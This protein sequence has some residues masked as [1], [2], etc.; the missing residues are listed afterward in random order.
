MRYE[1]RGK[2]PGQH[3]QQGSVVKGRWSRVWAWLGLAEATHGA[4]AVASASFGTVVGVAVCLLPVIAIFDPMPLL[5]ACAVGGILASGSG[6]WVWRS[7]R[8]GLATFLGTSGLLGAGF[9]SHVGTGSVG[10]PTSILYLA[11][12]ITAGGLQ[13]RRAAVVASTVAVALI[14]VGVSFGGALRAGLP[15]FEADYVVDERILLIFVLASIPCWG[16]YVVAIDAS[17]RE[18]WKRTVESNTALQQAHDDVLARS[19]ALEQAHQEQRIVNELTLLA[20][21]N[22]S[23]E[24]VEAACRSAVSARPESNPA[25]LQAVD[26]VVRARAIRHRLSEERADMASRLQR[27]MRVDAL[28]RLSAGI[29]H[30]FNNLLAVVMAGAE[31][32]VH[33][34]TLPP[35]AR[36]TATDIARTAQHAARVTWTLGQYARGLPLGGAHCDATATLEAL[37]PVLGS[38][39]GRAGHL[40][41]T[42]EPGLSVCLRPVDLERVAISLVAN[43][44]RAVSETPSGS[45]EV[46]LRRSTAGAVLRVRDNGVGMGRE[47]LERATEPYFSTG[48]GSGLGLAMVQGVA[49]SC[50]G[51]LQLDSTLGLGTTAMLM[52]PLCGLEHHASERAGVRPRTALVVDDEPMVRDSMA[53]LLEA[54]GL[55][56]R[57]AKD[58]KG[59]LA[60]VDAQE[61]ELLV[62][63]VQLVGE[64]GFELVRLARE[65]GLSCPVLYV[66]GFAGLASE[67]PS[68]RTTLLYKPFRLADLQ[69][70]IEALSGPG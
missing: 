60:E 57:V 21:G 55:Q 70:A 67:D 35:A 27:Q 18:A 63:D 54:C 44:A 20:C 39:V 47:T 22:A 43:A 12:V 32:L 49:A 66:T 9:V 30:D 3:A 28:E 59:A 7:G 29:A 6:A 52:M 17:N 56:V 65:R 15:V 69:A 24:A 68:P 42:L 34:G 13:G 26:Q 51:E 58:S 40:E 46:E 64:S 62:C 11:A 38:T 45:V 23:L 37:R 10:G 36:A 25:F 4:T 2:V 50:G 33:D 1:W 16:A 53:L 61:P 5:F 41:M 8:H 14:L 19:V 31:G 48:V